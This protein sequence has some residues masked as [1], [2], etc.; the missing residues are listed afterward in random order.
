MNRLTKC[1][2]LIAAAAVLSG[3]QSVNRGPV[4]S[5]TTFAK[6]ALMPYVQSGQLPGAINVFYKNG[7]QEKRVRCQGCG[8][9]IRSDRDLEGVEYVKTKRGSEWFFH[10]ACA[11]NVWR[12]KIC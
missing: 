8:K 11:E 1:M 4:D 7:V 12:R 10:T 3:C 9:W 5:K 2:M 6:D